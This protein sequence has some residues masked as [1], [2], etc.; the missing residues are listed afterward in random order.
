MDL[1]KLPARLMTDQVF[2]L[3]HIIEKGALTTVLGQTFLVVPLTPMTLDFI[4]GTQLPEFNNNILTNKCDVPDQS[5]S[6]SI[7]LVEGITLKELQ[8]RYLADVTGRVSLITCE[9]YVRLFGF[10]FDILGE[11][12]R[13]KTITRED[14]L[15]VRDLFFRIPLMAARHCRGLNLIEA[16]EKADRT[17]LRRI[18]EKTANYLLFRISAVFNWAERQ[19]LIDRNPAKRLGRIVNRSTAKF[20]RRP[21]SI[22]N[23]QR[24]FHLPLYTGCRDDFKYF[25]QTGPNHP[26]NERFWIPLVGLF[27]GMRVN[28]ILQMDIADVVRRDNIWCFYVTNRSLE[29]PS[30]KRLKSSAA[31]RY[32]PIHSALLHIGFIDFLEDAKRS[33]RQR[34]F[35]RAE[36]DKR[37]LFGER[38]SCWFTQ[39]F[40]KSQYLYHPETTF[41]SFRHNFR[42]ALRSGNASVFMMKEVCGWSMTGVEFGYGGPPSAAELART[43][44]LVRYPGLDLSHLL[45]D[46]GRK[47]VARQMS[48]IRRWKPSTTQFDEAMLKV[49][50]T[51]PESG[52][53]SS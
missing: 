3:G 37:G 38:Y 9:T 12:K 51:Y 20:K 28:E 4:N 21:F 6:P 5:I 49:I 31:E 44:E 19:W 43:V 1:R 48:A 14:M 52:T 7:D 53:S 8:Q 15:R 32:V 17:G 30:Q 27:S 47:A 34:L 11:G 50:S 22:E 42:D 40:L 26:R 36:M 23:L 24:L 13:L 2:V 18:S 25:R 29:G 45:T 41:H 10:L 46:S 39:T 35:P 16:I 33:G